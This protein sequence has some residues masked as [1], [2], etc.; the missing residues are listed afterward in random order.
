MKCAIL[1][2][3][4][5]SYTESKFVI[6]HFTPPEE[7]ENTVRVISRLFAGAL[8]LLVALP[9]VAAHAAGPLV[10]SEPRPKQ[11][12]SRAPGWVTLAFGHDLD[13]GIAKVVVTDSSGQP[14]TMNAPIVEGN[15]ITMQLDDGL[16]K[17]T[18]TVYYRVND[19]S[20]GLVGGAFQFAYGKGKWTKVEGSSW[21]GEDA[22]PPIL[23]DTDVWG[24]PVREAPETPL[25]AVVVEQ[26]GGPAISV[27][28]PVP[29][30]EPSPDVEEGPDVEGDPEA[31]EQAPESP[32]AVSAE[33]AGGSNTGL[34][35]G[36]VVAVAAAVAVPVV[37]RLR[38]RG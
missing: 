27:A 26:S 25:P 24:R 17:D 1:T 33:V 32:D 5:R 16:S 35:V 7:Q 22:Q 38:R 3:T 10:A 15:N 30:V 34:I 9:A 11:E 23:A 14:V 37:V 13:T 36:I 20:G 21:E 8:F 29:V 18:Y 4:S 2:K 28:A 31:T 19:S 6:P 12:L